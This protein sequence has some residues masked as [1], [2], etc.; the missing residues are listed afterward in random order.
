VFVFMPK[1][2]N[3]CRKGKNAPELTNLQ[4]SSTVSLGRHTSTHRDLPFPSGRTSTFKLQFYFFGSQG[5][6][7]SPKPIR[8]P[9][10]FAPPPH[11]ITRRQAGC[12]RVRNVPVVG[13]RP[14]I[15][16]SLNSGL[17]ART[18][19]GV[20]PDVAPMVTSEGATIGLR[21]DVYAA[22]MNNKWHPSAAGRVP[23]KTALHIVEASYEFEQL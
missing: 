20:R 17:P 4:V 21:P 2:G 3:A 18:I 5:S 22:I 19:I 9:P 23:M 10:Y 14:D 8:H 11:R 12:S 15:A 7:P 13:I 16:A 1:R 6:S